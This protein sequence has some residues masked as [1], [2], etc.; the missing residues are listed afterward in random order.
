MGL[1]IRLV[2]LLRRHIRLYPTQACEA[3]KPLR[4]M[5]GLSAVSENPYLTHRGDARRFS[6]R[7]SSNL[8]ER[9]QGQEKCTICLTQRPEPEFPVLVCRD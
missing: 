1:N 6:F 4:E 8:Q 2:F 7:F 3:G 9:H 5:S